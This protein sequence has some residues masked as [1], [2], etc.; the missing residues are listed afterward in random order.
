MAASPAAQAGSQTIVLE[1]H[2]EKERIS[3]FSVGSWALY[4][5]ANT[6]F[7][8]NIIS[9]YFPQFI[10]R[11]RGLND[12]VYAYP[13]SVALLIVALIM[14]ALGA[15]S[16]RNGGRRMP[17]LIA[18]TLLTVLMTALMG[19]TGELPLIILAL[20]I[21]NIGYQTALIFYDALLPSV[22][23]TLNWGKVSGLGVGLGY[24]GALL[25]GAIVNVLITQSDG[26]VAAQDAFLPTAVLFLVFALPCFFL[27]RER[28]N[29]RIDDPTA[30]RPT[31]Q[32]SLT[33]TAR[34]LREAR[35]VPGLFTFLV[36]NFFYSDALNTVIIAMGV[37]AV[38]VIGFSSAFSVLAPAILTA[39]IGS[40]LFGLVTDWLTS[41]Q[42]LII[43]LLMWV[44]VFAAAMFIT[45]KV[46]FQWV[47]APV[48]GIALGSTWT[49][50]RTMMIELSPPERLGEFLGLYNL[51]GK[52]SAVLGPLLWGTTLLLLDPRQ[53]GQFA[54]QVAIA[55]LLVMVLI[56]LALHLRTPNI[57]RQRSKSI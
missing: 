10:V 13:M 1:S 16:D 4:D 14:P 54:Y 7:S 42:A 9:V 23:T 31:L 25:G 18:T 41:K 26:R 3:P 32:G 47:I 15:F 51:T 29:A 37:Y 43:A 56:G 39:V 19:V 45:D 8:L 12:A 28:S 17:W 48:A 57:R 35:K 50:A 46:I 34:T 2:D 53:Y 11:D 6:I 49:A 24:A 52:F 36:A 20:V 22:S 27:V 44:G 30:P 33:Q 5:F 21:A 40:L 38:Q 55:T